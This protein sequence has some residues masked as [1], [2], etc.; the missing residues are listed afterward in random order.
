M[1]K[2]SLQKFYL[3]TIK[4]VSI[5]IIGRRA[6]GKTFLTKKIINQNKTPDSKYVVFEHNFS[7]GYEY[8]SEYTDITQPRFICNKFDSNKLISYDE[9][10]TTQ[11]FFVCD[12]M[13]EKDIL[14]D[15]SVKQI[16]MNRKHNNTCC[17][18][19]QQYPININPSNLDYI[20]IFYEQSR[21]TKNKI[22]DL[23]FRDTS[24]TFS[25]FDDI[26]DSLN[27]YECLVI[28]NIDNTIKLYYQTNVDPMVLLR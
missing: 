20:F 25:I 6:S 21:Q 15:I 7:R 28:D 3:S 26:L 16:Y 9:F 19:T 22:Y 2:L 18:F 17:I 5:L 24:M 27:Q 10:D 8:P 12:N 14:K 4:N 1:N 11:K 23:Y 13:L